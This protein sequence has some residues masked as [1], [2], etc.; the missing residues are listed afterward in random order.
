MVEKSFGGVGLFESRHLGPLPIS[1]VKI[2]G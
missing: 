1:D 2:R